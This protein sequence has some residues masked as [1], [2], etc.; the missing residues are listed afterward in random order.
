VLDS[1]VDGCEFRLP[2][3]AGSTGMGDRLRARKPPQYFTTLPMPTQPPT[4]SG[5]ET[6]IYQPKCGGAPRLGSKGRYGSF[7]LWINLWL[8]GK[9]CGPC[10]VH[11]AT[12]TRFRNESRQSAIEIYS[13]TYY[14]LLNDE[15]TWTWRRAVVSSVEF[16]V[17]CVYTRLSRMATTAYRRRTRAPEIDVYRIIR[18][19]TDAR[20]SV[21]FTTPSD[22]TTAAIPSTTSTYPTTASPAI[23]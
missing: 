17:T 11:G 7:H 9:W 8:A 22:Q 5:T 23:C 10:R 3:A 20:R 21:S 15:G 6:S 18:S 1:R 2:A 13:Y 14:T 19:V 4:L 12:P 16:L